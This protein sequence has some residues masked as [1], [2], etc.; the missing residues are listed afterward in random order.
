MCVQFITTPSAC[1]TKYTMIYRSFTSD[2]FG[3]P[4]FVILY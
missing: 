1:D 3:Q 2:E 4:Q